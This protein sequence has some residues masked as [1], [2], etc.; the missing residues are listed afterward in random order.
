MLVIAMLAARSPTA[1]AQAPTFR[2]VT[3]HR[4]GERITE[5][6]QMLT[7]L[8][9]LDQ[10]SDRVVV[11]IQGQ[12]W[13]GRPLPV[14]IVTAPE[15]HAR[16]ETIQA[17]A[18]RLG[19][20]RRLPPQE[21]DALLE[22]QPVILWYG[23]SIH[24]FELS[25]SEGALKLLEHLTTSSD[26]ATLEVLRNAVI[27]IDPMLNPDGRDAHTHI[28]HENVGRESSAKP[29]DWSNDFTSWQALKFRTGHY[30]FDT[31]RDWFAHTQ[32]ETRAR[33]PT[34]QAWRP[35][36][37]V[38]LHE[39]GVD[40]EFYFDPPGEPYGPYFPPYAFR[41]FKE[42]GNAYAAA[43]DS[44]GFEY[45]T[46]ERY[47]YFYPGYTTSYGS[48]QGAVGM[49]YE[50]G[51]TRGLALER[52]DRTVRTLADAL[53][54]Q[55]VAAWTAA[56]TAVARRRELQREYYEAHRQ[57]VADGAQGIRRYYIGPDGDP[58]LRRELASLLVR[59][60]IEVGVLEA[61]LTASRLR[62]RSG[63]AVPQLTLPSGTFVVEAAQPRNRLL[64]SLLEPSNELPAD[65]LRQARAYVDRD[66]NPRFY[67]ITAWSLPLLFNVGVYGSGDPQLPS[68]T[69]WQPDASA[70]SVVP[71]PKASY[72]YLL[73]GR[74]AASVAALY[75]LRAA[76]HRV[77]VLTAPTQIAGIAYGSGTGIVRVG[78]NGPGVHDA[79]RNLARRYGLQVAA[80]N[81]GL[82]DPGFPALG[83]G[84]HTFNLA[85]ASIA[86]LAEDPVFAYS[87]G[88]A[89]YTLDRQYE[90]PTTVLR[91][92][93]LASTDLDRFNVLVIPSVSGQ[94]LATAVGE[95]GVERV[96]QWV[97]EGGTLVTIGAATDFA[98]EQL[99]LIAL[100]D[101][102]ETDEGADSTRYDVPGAIVRAELDHGYWLS[103][104]YDASTLPVLV[105]SDRLYLAPDGP[106]SSSRRVVARYAGADSLLMSG[107]VWDES[108]RRLPGAV[109]LYEQ[110]VGR[111]RVI[112]FAEDVN[113]RAYFRGANRLFLNAVI[114]GPSGN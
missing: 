62:D 54:Q 42:F 47:N 75:H 57:A 15:N 103:A 108:R 34:L 89:W 67:D 80:V 25:G 63:S 74:S 49:L 87:F 61:P 33:V 68:S 98:R 70:S 30:Y 82:S 43:F 37:V 55:Y 66:E 22:D 5:H 6:H 17:V 100:R 71:P 102:Y 109:F 79:V 106:P 111:G 7:Y 60:G 48:Y 50:Q 53:E 81:S 31:N 32:R 18:Q 3:G 69:P 83:S 86:I 51:S 104:G 93:S 8:R 59:N 46:R 56:R 19:D 105:D 41:W 36:V 38:D 23:G 24:G 52:S 64:R 65:F 40:A 29:Q 73:D 13:E 101:W 10:A 99:D 96:A 9:A 113:F 90:I 85:P 2:E 95:G 84:D 21:I 94:A 77:G 91:T 26:P 39:M 97:R 78:Q 1:A 12:S 92:R 72:A 112:S 45:M 4:F 88:W 28:N 110:R 16:L 114:L 35:Q 44:A 11:Q 27:L 76:G 14:A 58:V 107:H 20:P